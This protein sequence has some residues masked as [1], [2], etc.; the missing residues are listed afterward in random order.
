MRQQFLPELSQAEVKAAAMANKG[1]QGL[2]QPLRPG[3]LQ[4]PAT[5]QFH[6]C[7]ARA[8]PSSECPHL[9]CPSLMVLLQGSV[10]SPPQHFLMGRCTPQAHSPAWRISSIVP[11]GCPH[12][13]KALAVCRP[14]PKAQP[15]ERHH[16]CTRG[17]LAAH[18]AGSHGSGLT[19]VL[20]AT[21]RPHEA[22]PHSCASAFRCDSPKANL[23]SAWPRARH[24]ARWAG[25][26]AQ[27]SF[28]SPSLGNSGL[29]HVSSPRCCLLLALC[30]A[31]I[32]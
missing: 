26:L 29:T 12:F 14:C 20:E 5:A 16:S 21:V 25:H 2:G 18:P 17:C 10:A 15:G 6:W 7:P 22:M 11:P 31:L 19:A 3:Q 30:F 4:G 27:L 9:C 1:C 13:P 8:V 28:S 24:Y 23:G 32:P